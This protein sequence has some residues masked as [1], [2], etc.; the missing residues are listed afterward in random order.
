MK[1][2]NMTNN[3]EEHFMCNVCCTENIIIHH[4]VTCPKCNFECC[5]KCIE[6]YLTSIPTVTPKCMSCNIE[7]NMDFISK[8][9]RPKFHKLNYRNYRAKLILEHERSL[10]PSTQHLLKEEKMKEKVRILV[11]KQKLYQKRYDSLC[12]KVENLEDKYLFKNGEYILIEDAPKQVRMKIQQL[13]RKQSRALKRK[14]KAKSEARKVRKLL[15]TK[16]KTQVQKKERVICFCPG[17]NCNGFISNK[18]VCGTCDIKVCGKCRQPKHDDDCDPNLVENVKL[19]KK[20]TKPCPKCT[21]PIFKISGCD[22]MWCVYCHTPFS[23]RTG[24]VVTGV[25]HNPHFY[26]WQRNENGGIAPRVP[27]DEPCGGPLSIGKLY[28]KL[29]KLNIECQDIVNAHRV[30]NH[31]KDVSLR[32]S[33]PLVEFGEVDNTDLRISF[34]MNYI[35]EKQWLKTLK[36]REKKREKN[37]CI[38]LILRMFVNTMDDLF[39]SMVRKRTIE[40][41]IGVYE[42]MLSLRK[43]VNQELNKIESRFN[44]KVPSIENNW[45]LEEVGVQRFRFV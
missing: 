15:K 2:T 40:T 27:G 39:R 34:L 7:W 6:T 1:F 33:H 43:Y 29:Q 4:M 21:I 9:T 23:W 13:E 17:K 24:E 31:I 18:Y 26:E 44:N 36:M 19:M 38:H 35:T 11:D 5:R 14:E 28:T 32:R 45:Y 37:R 42:Q 41:I 3:Q 22:Q 25:V 10:L 8:V 16:D 12:R 30:V 20:D